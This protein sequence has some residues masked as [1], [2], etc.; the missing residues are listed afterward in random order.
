[1][2]SPN[3]I[4]KKVEALVAT[5]GMQSLKFVTRSIAGVNAL[6]QQKQ[7]QEDQDNNKDQDNKHSP[8]NNEELEWKSDSDDEEEQTCLDEAEL[9]DATGGRDQHSDNRVWIK[10][11]Q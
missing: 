6:S 8:D 7:D 5:D 11:V 10:Q 9:D 1:M 4:I 3:R 2:P